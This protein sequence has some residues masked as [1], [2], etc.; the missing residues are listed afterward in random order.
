MTVF[1]KLNLGSVTLPYALSANDSTFPLGNTDANAYSALVGINEHTWVKVTDGVATEVIKIGARD[2][3]NMIPVLQRGSTPVAFAEGA[4]ASYDWTDEAIAEMYPES[5][6]DFVNGCGAT[7][8]CPCDD[9]PTE[10]IVNQQVSIVVP[11]NGAPPSRSVTFN[12]P[13][14]SYSSTASAIVITGTPT[15]AGTFALYVRLVKGGLS[16]SMNCQIKIVDPSA[17]SC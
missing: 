16:K 7:T 11:Y 14:M 9:L 8:Q 15:S 3:L 10:L 17:S 6:L 1:K 4:C 2:Y 12:A 13:G 5:G